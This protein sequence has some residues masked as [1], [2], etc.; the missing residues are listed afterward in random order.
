VRSRRT[1]R[2]VLVDDQPAVRRGLRMWLA[3]EPDIV[4]VGESE[5]GCDL[6]GL[7]DRLRPDVLVMDL[8]MPGPGGMTITARVHAAIPGLPIVVL[9]L[10]DDIETR[11]RAWLAGAAAFVSKHDAE[12]SLAATIRAVARCRLGV[13]TDRPPTPGSASG[14]C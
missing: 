1:I 7:I 2:L 14:V 11:T 8:G 4:V 13:R 12:P 10:H 3:L 6:R 5:D 9:S